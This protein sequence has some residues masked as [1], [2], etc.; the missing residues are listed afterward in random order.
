VD[1]VR[2]VSLGTIGVRGTPTI[3]LV[4]GK[5]VVTKLWTG[6]L[7]AQAEDEVLAALRGVRS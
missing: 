6:K 3:L 7:Q 4:D 5:G 1:Q 2:Q